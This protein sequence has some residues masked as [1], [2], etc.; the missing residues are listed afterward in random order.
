MATG[1]K[2]S[3]SSSSNTGRPV[4]AALT[5]A[6]HSIAGTS[7][8][9][10]VATNWPT[11]T[12]IYFAIFE[13]ITV[14]GL[15]VK[16]TTTQTD[17]TG[18]L[19][20]LTISNMVLV[21]GV[22]R[23]YS[24]GAIVELT[25]VAKQWKDLYDWA[26]VGHTIEGLHTLGSS[27]TLTS[28][29]FITGL[30]DTNGNELLKLTAT[31]SAVNEFTVANAAT[32][33]S[34]ALSVTGSDSN[35]DVVVTPKGTGKLKVGG[36]P[37]DH[38]AWADWTPTWANFTPGSATITAKYAQVGKTV[39]FKLLVVLSS[40]TMGT[41]PTFTLPVTAAS[42]DLTNGI[43]GQ[44]VYKDASPAGT[45]N[46]VVRLETTTVAQPLTQIVSGTRI[47]IDGITSAAPFTWANSDTFTCVGFYEA[48]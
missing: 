43:I 36:N 26:D 45:A 9:I 37:I 2:L 11:T 33:N 35:I 42:F 40:S 32:G 39:F 29:K 17:W 18:D 16:D 12:K 7:V 48:A 3:Q 27:D 21:G 22:D 46:G 20:T 4:S 8:T 38:G 1:D 14:G 13:T 47:T 6:G 15:T 34:P 41:S 28:A 24:A 19:S 23:D 31:G 30:N 10:N 5:G 25:P 44:S